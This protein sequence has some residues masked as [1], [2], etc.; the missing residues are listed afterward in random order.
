MCALDRVGKRACDLGFNCA[1][2]GAPDALGHFADQNRGSD[3]L[4]YERSKRIKGKTLV[5]TTGD[6]DDRLALRA[7]CLVHCVEVGRLGIVHIGDAVD[8]AYK[9]AA[10][11]T[12]LV[13]TEW[14]HHFSE[15]QSA[16]HAD[17]KGRHQIL[18]VMQATQL[19]IGQSQNCFVAVKNRAFRDSEVS[20]IG[21]GAKRDRALTAIR[22]FFDGIQD[23]HI[24]IGLMFKNAQLGC[25]IFRYRAITIEM[26]RSE[27]KPETDGWMKSANRLQ[28]ERAYLHREHVV[29]LLLACHFGQRFPNISAGYRSLAASI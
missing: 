11:R 26:V 23:C 3:L 10:M 29:R 16:R 14:R 2:P 27:I 17:G 8:F 13:I 22:Y 6:Q 9:F 18:D 28:L 12:R 25:T 1:S 5:L 4:L 19:S 20:T 21:I 7:Q 15:R 24:A